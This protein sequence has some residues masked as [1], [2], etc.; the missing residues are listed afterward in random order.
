MKERRRKGKGQLLQEENKHLS[1]GKR[2]F[3][4]K[5]KKMGNCQS[6]MSTYEII[7]GELLKGENG[8]HFEKGVGALN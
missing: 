4:K 5:K 2:A 1:K 7:I 6:K 8:E 3:V